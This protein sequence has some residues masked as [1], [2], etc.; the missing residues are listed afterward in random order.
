MRNP[1]TTK[2][3]FA[4]A[5]AVF[6]LAGIV[7]LAGCGTSPRSEPGTTGGTYEVI[8]VDVDGHSVPCVVWDGHK[9]GGITCDWGVTA[10]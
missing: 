3:I 5:A 9:A 10:R 7:A 1:R 6:A 2:L 4:A 8:H